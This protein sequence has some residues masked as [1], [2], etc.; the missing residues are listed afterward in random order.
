[1]CLLDWE[2]FIRNRY[3]NWGGTGFE[4]PL[5]YGLFY[6]VWMFPRYVLGRLPHFQEMYLGKRWSDNCKLTLKCQCVWMAACLSVLLFRRWLVWGCT[7]PKGSWE[8][9][10]DIPWSTYKDCTKRRR[11]KVCWRVIKH[12]MWGKEH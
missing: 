8:R 1:M 10:S 11:K 9:L 12:I 2:I 4:F 7:L 3:V 5:G 6:E